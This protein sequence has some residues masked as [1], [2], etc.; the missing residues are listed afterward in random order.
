[1]SWLLLRRCLLCHQEEEEEGTNKICCGHHCHL[2]D[3]RC[4][5][6]QWPEA[7]EVVP[8][9]AELLYNARLRHLLGHHHRR[10]PHLEQQRLLLRL[11]LHLLRG[12]ASA[13]ARQQQTSCVLW[14][15]VAAARCKLAAATARGCLPRC[16]VGPS[17]LVAVV[18][19][20][21]RAATAEVVWCLPTA[22]K[23]L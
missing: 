22:S 15:P 11:Q 6:D 12:A 1:M 13:L 4:Q 14:R 23:M 3:R 5:F 16:A 2:C 19:T 20:M 8:P 18:A 9:G 17:L 21:S 7:A 10:R